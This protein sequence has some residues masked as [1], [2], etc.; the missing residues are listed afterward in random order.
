M[1]LVGTWWG[2]PQPLIR[3]EI[4]YPIP[5][6]SWL[7]FLRL[8]PPPQL[9]LEKPILWEREVSGGKQVDIS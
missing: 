8:C 6:P 7:C 2:R 9:L 1:A 4:S 5:S 3:W